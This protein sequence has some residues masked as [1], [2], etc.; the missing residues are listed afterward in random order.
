MPAV[1]PALVGH[2]R[3]PR[4]R[5]VVRSPRHR[6][7]PTSRANRLSNV[8]RLLADAVRGVRGVRHQ[9]FRGARCGQQRPWLLQS[10]PM[11]S[12]A[13]GSCEH[14]FVAHE[15]DVS[16]T[17]THTLC[18]TTLCLRALDDQA[19]KQSTQPNGRVQAILE[20]SSRPPLFQRP[21]TNSQKTCVVFR[22]KKNAALKHLHKQQLSFVT[23]LFH[24]EQNISPETRRRPLQQKKTEKKI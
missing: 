10:E 21:N 16:H 14:L 17:H 4:R 7:W 12:R 6:D 11:L 13:R 24:E 18:L 19:P 20:L 23:S 5:P 9:W 1:W 3:R 2:G 22:M 8:E 15:D